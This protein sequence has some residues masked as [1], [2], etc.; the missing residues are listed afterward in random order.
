MKKVVRCSEYPYY[1][2]LEIDYQDAGEDYEW[3]DVP[4]VVDQFDSIDSDY[5][6]ER[7]AK[8]AGLTGDL[9]DPGNEYVI[10]PY[11]ELFD[12]FCEKLLDQFDKL[13]AKEGDKYVTSGLYEVPVWIPEGFDYEEEIGS[14]YGPKDGI[15]R[16]FA[17]LPKMKVTFRKVQ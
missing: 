17:D 3:H 14:G 10:V 8:A 5:D 6:Q 13:H 1:Y 16:E 2:D 15:M 12:D 9:M 11:D 4:F 7:I